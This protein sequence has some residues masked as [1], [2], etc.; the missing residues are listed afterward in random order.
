[1]TMWVQENG[2]EEIKP[3]MATIF[4]LVESQEQ[5]A[6]LTLVSNVYEQGVLEELIET[7]K[8]SFPD[9][10]DSLH[11]LLKTPF[12]YPPLTHGSR[13]GRSF[14]SSLFYGSLNIATALTETAYYRFVYMLGP[15]TPFLS[16]IHSEYTSFSVKIKSNRGVFLD[17]MPFAKHESL[18]TSPCSYAF[19]Q[20]LGSVMRKNNIEVF[21]Y[22]SARDKNKGKNVALFTPNAFCCRRPLNSNS[23]LCQTT[24]DAIGFMSKSDENRMLF[25]QKDFWIDGLFPQPAV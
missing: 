25:F 19:T 18:L 7:M 2:I 1:M 22:I 17:E 20:E 14:E 23:W 15:V 8:S 9:E 4:R 3:F 12:R 6:T 11:Y 5:V 10:T 13:F 24:I 16:T 21:R